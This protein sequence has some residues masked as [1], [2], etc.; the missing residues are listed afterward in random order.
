MEN[1]YEY[2]LQIL[3]DLQNE[4]I[5]INKRRKSLQNKIKNQSKL[6]DSLKTKPEKTVDTLLIRDIKICK[7]LILENKRVST[8]AM[9]NYLNS[10]LKNSETRWQHNKASKGKLDSNIFMTVL[11]K[12]IK[13]ID[14][15]KTLK[16][17]CPISNRLTTVWYV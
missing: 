14:G 16:E 11:G 1:S 5:L 4:L 3:K 13:A 9:I 12:H 6:V 7:D 2:N 15:V 17:K 10:V 8:G